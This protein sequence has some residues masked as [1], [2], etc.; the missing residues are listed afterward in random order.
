MDVEF[1]LVGGP[2][3]GE[4]IHAHP[5][6]SVWVHVGSAS[7]YRRLK[8]ATYKRGPLGTPT[9]VYEREFFVHES[10]RDQNRVQLLLQLA[11]LH[12]WFTGGVVRKLSE[13]ERD[14]YKTHQAAVSDRARLNGGTP[15]PDPTGLVIMPGDE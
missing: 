6:A 11:A 12:R 4:T 3:H 8:F 5:Q 1:L 15:K 9:G 13:E 10:V 2:A 14:L 7:T